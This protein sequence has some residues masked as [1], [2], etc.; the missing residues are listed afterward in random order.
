ELAAAPA[1]RDLDDLAV[2][3]DVLVPAPV[4]QLSRRDGGAAG[5][6]EQL[7]HGELLRAELEPATGAARDPLDGVEPDVPARQDRREGRE[8]SAGER[9]DPGDE[10]GEREGL[11]QVVV[12]PETEP[13]DAVLDRVGSGEHQDTRPRSARDEGA[14]YIVAVQLGQVA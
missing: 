3:I 8:A 7:E 13:V 14:A 12:G 11:G 6:E 2:G 10:L 4:E 1:D 9:A 5:G